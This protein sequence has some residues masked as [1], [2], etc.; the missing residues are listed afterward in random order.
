MWWKDCSCHLWKTEMPFQSLRQCSNK[1][2]WILV[3]TDP[4]K[5]YISLYRSLAGIWIIFALAWLA[6]ILNMG[7]RIMEHVIG[8]THP[9]FKKQEEEDVS[10][11]KLEDMSKI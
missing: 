3:G 11:S 8:L 1:V 6:L 10:S 2:M 5:E 4:G 7:T 9:G